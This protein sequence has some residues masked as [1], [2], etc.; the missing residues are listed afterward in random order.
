MTIFTVFR[1]PGLNGEKLPGAIA[2]HFPN[3]FLMIGDDIWLVA[4]KSTAQE[5]SDKL[6]IS[7]GDNGSG[8]VLAVSS[9]FGRANPNIWDWIK[10]KWEAVDG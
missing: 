4:G 7:T 5:V 8:V 9:Y 1:Q 6:G 10:T 2:E 3:N